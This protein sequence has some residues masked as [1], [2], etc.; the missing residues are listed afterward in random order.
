M[1]GTHGGHVFVYRGDLTRLSCDAVL[2]PTDRALHITAGWRAYFDHLTLQSPGRWLQLPLDRPE[3]WTISTHAFRADAPEFGPE[4]WLLNSGADDPRPEWVA[5]VVSRAVATVSAEGNHGRHRRKRLIGLPLVG[6]GDGGFRE[7][8]GALIE[9]LLRR[10]NAAAIDNDVDIALVLNDARDM[11]AVTA[12]RRDPTGWRGL[13][14]DLQ[15]A[16]DELGHLAAEGGLSLFLGAGVS[17]PLG[18]PDWKSLVAALTSDACLADMNDEHLLDAAQAAVDVLG[19]D[20]FRDL[21]QREFTVRRHTLAHGLLATLGIEQVVTTN[22][23]NAYELADQAARGDDQLRVLVRDLPAP[24]TRWLLKI[25]GDVEA[26]RTVVLTRDQYSELAHRGAPLRGMVQSLLMTSHLLFVGY[27]LVDRTFLLLADQVRAVLADSRGEARQVATVL[28]ITRD[29]ELGERCRP[30]LGLVEMPVGRGERVAGARLLELF[31]DR[32]VWKAGR[33]R[34]DAVLHL[35]DERYAE[36][37]R[38]P[39]DLE[40]QRTLSEFIEKAPARA[41]SSQGWSHVK[42]ALLRLGADESRL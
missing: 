38:P 41:K 32:V 12:A 20:R 35:L 10:L 13:T 15:D 6:T 42:S 37:D 30:D 33:V 5:E 18:L 16:A 19:I 17:V 25:H 14:E 11:A 26:P 24:Q 4:V 23:D 21:V 28:S 22:Y 9:E 7:Q 34:D 39:E 2:V 40:L 36:L 8:R 29:A 1:S 27:S 31:L 3:G